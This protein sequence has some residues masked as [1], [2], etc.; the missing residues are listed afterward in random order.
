MAARN[1]WKLT[2]YASNT[3]LAS[4]VTPDAY[5]MTTVT[6]ASIT[7]P[8]TASIFIIKPEVK[9]EIT[10]EM[11]EDVGGERI[12]FLQRRGTMNVQSYPFNYD[13]TSDPFQQDMDDLI[14]F[15]NAATGKQYLH[16]RIEGGSRSYPAA[17]YA[18]PVVIDSWEESINSEAGTRTLD[19]VLKHRE[20]Y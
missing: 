19:V 18:Y 1:N 4:G 9:P 10:P 16:V 7:A 2:L 17:G 12:T 20:R 15:A 11:I 3:R 14:S 13:A 6:I 8:T 5:G